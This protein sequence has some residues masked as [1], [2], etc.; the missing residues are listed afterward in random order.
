MSTRQRKRRDDRRRRHSETS[1]R[2]R[3]LLAAG[4]LTAGATLALAGPAHAAT[5]FTVG[6]PADTTG[7]SDC[8]TP[9][10]TD[11]TLRQA[12]L[13]AN[14][15][16]GADTIVFA[17]SLSGQTITLTTDP[18]QITEAVSIQGPGAGQ[19]TVD[20][21][22]N[23]RDFDVEPAT[24]GDAVS[25]SGL[26]ITDGYANAD[27]G[28]IF[29]QGAN[30]TISQSLVS[31]SYTNG[32]SKYQGGGVYS[33]GPSVTIDHSTVHGNHSWQGGGVGGTNGQVTISD[34]TISGNYADGD[35]A[36]N[37][38]RGYGGGVFS[39]TANVTIDRSTISDNTGAY[40]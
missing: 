32:A 4:G 21:N 23:Y 11:C 12:I 25:I 16:P 7:A 29:N 2:H 31:D 19:L 26:T 14:T 8:T 15:N 35:P 22:G 3:R 20:G 9:G 28:A 13:D 18:A 27:G 36:N 34:S 6:S 40:D 24:S 30:L 10:N 5:T 37:G 33:A 39:N 38:A 17:S 1:P